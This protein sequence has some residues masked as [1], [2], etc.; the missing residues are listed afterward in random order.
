MKML[1]VSTKASE[2]QKHCSSTYTGRGILH[3]VPSVLKVLNE[4]TVNR[5]V[6]NTMRPGF[7][8]SKWFELP[9][10]PQKIP[11]STGPEKWSDPRSGER[12]VRGIR[13]EEIIEKGGKKAYSA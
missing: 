8:S 12:D 6:N 7:E 1:V 10:K 4:V 9:R 5:T 3:Y 11:A 13:K 2:E